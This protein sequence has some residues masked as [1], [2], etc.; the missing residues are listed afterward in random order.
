[1]ARGFNSISH[2]LMKHHGGK[3]SLLKV[4]EAAHELNCSPSLVYQ[5]IADGRLRCHRIGKGQGGI[6]ISREQLDEF[7]KETVKGGEETAKLEQLKRP[8]SQELRHLH[9][10]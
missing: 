6:R 2:A 1:M 4:Q 3:M 8:K 10:D 9:L 5:A 7:L